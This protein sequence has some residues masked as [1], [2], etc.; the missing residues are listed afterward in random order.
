M[1]IFYIKEVIISRA[2]RLWYSHQT[3]IGGAF[4]AGVGRSVIV[5]PQHVVVLGVD[6]PV[7]DTWM[8]VKPAARTKPPDIDCPR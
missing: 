8:C 2:R 7:L 1:R 5:D 6:L 4:R 3:K